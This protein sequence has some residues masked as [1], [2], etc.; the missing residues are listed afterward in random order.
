MKIV[1]S[2]KF[3]KS[4]KN[5][6]FYIAKDKKSAAI[7][8]KKDLQKIIQDLK[9]MPYKYRKSY[10]YEKEE[11]RDLV[12]RGYVIPYLIDDDKIIILDIFKWRER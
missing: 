5:I 10:F 1:E 9:F 12:F 3:K 8:F 11:V 2:V 7:K 6:L 4:L